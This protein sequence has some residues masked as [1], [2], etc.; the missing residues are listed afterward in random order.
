MMLKYF[1]IMLFN[2][3]T[4]FYWKS[5]IILMVHLSSLLYTLLDYKHFPLIFNMKWN[6]IQ[7]DGC[8]AD[9]WEFLLDWIILEAS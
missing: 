6:L 7:Y 5:I 8:D 4:K 9:Y 2:S 3:S 1:K